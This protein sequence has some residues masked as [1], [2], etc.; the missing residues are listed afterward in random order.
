MSFQNKSRLP[1][2]PWHIGYAY[3]DENDPRR[4]KARCIHLDN[5]SG[6]CDMRLVRCYG[7]SHCKYYA[8]SV[9]QWIEYLEAMKT[10]EEKAEE[11]AEFRAA[12]Y[13]KKKRDYVRSLLKDIV[14]LKKIRLYPT[15]VFCPFCGERL[16][17]NQCKFCLAQ[18]YVVNRIDEESA[19]KAAEQGVFLVEAR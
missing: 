13:R 18:F 10:E 16:K 12:M 15:M 6:T 11:A 8:E 5:K 17:K 14:Y 1:D 2:T 3:K 4:H 19:R 9:E 7:S